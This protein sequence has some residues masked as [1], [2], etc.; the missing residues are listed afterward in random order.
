MCTYC[1]IHLTLKYCKWPLLESFHLEVTLETIDLKH[2]LNFSC[3]KNPDALK[4]K[5]ADLYLSLQVF[6]VRKVNF[7]VV[8]KKS[9]CYNTSVYGTNSI[10]LEDNYL[11]F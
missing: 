1:F 7:S 5:T 8:I 4:G 11:S 9:F 6:R 10:I 2:S 3:E